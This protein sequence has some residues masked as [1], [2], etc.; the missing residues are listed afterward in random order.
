MASFLSSL[1]R[2]AR[3]TK[4]TAS[5]SPSPPHHP[6]TNTDIA[7]SQHSLRTPYD[8]T[9]SSTGS[10]SSSS[11]SR[12]TSK[13]SS[14][15]SSSTASAWLSNILPGST[16]LGRKQKRH[17][18]RSSRSASPSPPAVSATTAK[19]L[20][21]YKP[22]NDLDASGATLLASEFEAVH[23]DN[24]SNAK[25]KRSSR[26][27]GG[28]GGTAKGT[29]GD[30]DG[31]QQALRAPKGVRWDQ[32]LSETKD[33][34]IQY[35]PMTNYTNLAT[36]ADLERPSLVSYPMLD[37]YRFI[38][39]MGEGAFSIVYK[40]VDTKTKFLVA[41]K[42]V[43]KHQL[44]D[45][46][47]TN[48][49][50]ETSLLGRLTH[51][52]II[53]LFDF[54]ETPTHFA[55]VLELMSGG[56]IF[57]Q[58]V[59]QVCFS[60]PLCRHII[61]QVAESLRY[62]HDEKGVVH[63]DIKL[64]NLLYEPIPDVLKKKTA[65]PGHHVS[66]VGGEQNIEDDY[67]EGVGGANIG[68]VK[69]ADFG[70][71]KVVFNATTKTPCG[72]VGY[73]AP[74]IL[75]DQ[76]YSKGVDM[77]ALGCVLYTILSGFPPFFD[78]DPRGLTEKVANG[79]FAFLS[80]WWDDISVEAKDLV[81][82]LLEVDPKKRYSISE[83]LAHPWMN[84][85]RF[86]L[87]SNAPAIVA[88]TFTAELPLQDPTPQGDASSTGQ[89]AD[90]PA[91]PEVLHSPLNVGFEDTMRVAHARTAPTA[92]LPPL[93]ADTTTA[94]SATSSA[95]DDYFEPPSTAA[96]VMAVDASA[97]AAVMSP[98]ALPSPYVGQGQGQAKKPLPKTQAAKLQ[99]MLSPTGNSQGTP[100]Y[101]RLRTPHPVPDGIT[102]E[103]L[104]APYQVYKNMA[105]GE[106]K[107][108]YCGL[109]KGGVVPQYNTTSHSGKKN[110]VDPIYAPAGTTAT[111]TAAN[112]TTKRGSPRVSGAMNAGH[113]FALDMEHSRL[114]LKRRKGEGMANA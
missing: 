50:R 72:T 32:K 54:I 85:Q 88:P 41:V 110:R 64:E 40:A 111:T 17:H 46:Q 28:A 57:H 15:G 99:S 55:L 18:H 83:F 58:L 65:G 109:V 92:D 66:G 105:E 69:L 112:A 9:A 42:L 52:N 5:P 67:V 34:T 59:A 35:H 78:D 97:A 38:E 21:S 39:K 76:R 91:L 94:S 16:S 2:S 106:S 43:S 96:G 100:T 11:G 101:R 90:W 7:D 44:N 84:G 49:L 19:D 80:P 71:S 56:E 108:E 107:P 13:R 62:L 70:L 33:R 4:D 113:G 36:R 86:V 104:A 1:L 114:F 95:S 87:K 8:S 60:E 75:R 30:M 31:L 74:E 6:S 48:I 93:P 26:A 98:M 81:Q 14:P 12:S 89:Y 51:P 77:W 61:R 103:M 45:T 47:R 82:H 68:L 10:S 23:L 73:T 79:Q 53:R 102:K 20:N 3:G 27:A 63:R 29:A 24:D 37:R 22:K 25:H